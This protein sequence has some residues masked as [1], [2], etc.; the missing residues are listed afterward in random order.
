MT[1][2]SPQARVA[3]LV[4][5]QP[6]RARVF[7]RYGIDYCCGGAMPLEA[8]CA[9]R[10]IDPRE[11][12]AAL[13]EPRADGAEDV[14][15]KAASIAGLV[16]HIV[17]EHHAFLHEELTPLGAL[18]DKVARAHGE[19]HPELAGVQTTFGAVATELER[20]LA[21]EEQ[22]LFPALVALEGEGADRPLPGALRAS[23]ARAVDDHRDVAAGLARLRELT[24][25]YVPPEDSCN[26]YRAMLDRLETLEADTHRHV[27][28]ENN[29]L[30]PR[31][32]ALDEAR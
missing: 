23:V 6:S 18:V 25:A 22:V 24:G 13:E 20:H 17:G 2:I 12:L 11:V 32:L 9:E 21:E 3:G 15:W 4:L 14:D 8:A 26:S 1:T 16:D 27:H 30:F 31:A 28:E 29:V 19:A 7:E 10:G 5:E